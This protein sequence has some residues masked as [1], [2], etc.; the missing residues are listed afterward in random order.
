MYFVAYRVA[1][2]KYISGTSLVTKVD[3]DWSSY[4][5]TLTLDADTDEYFGDFPLVSN[6]SYLVTLYEQI[7]AEPVEADDEVIAEGVFSWSGITS[8]PDSSSDFMI[9]L[10]HDTDTFINEFAEPITYNE[11]SGD[12][13]TIRAVVNRSLPTKVGEDGRTLATF[14]EICIYNDAN[15]GIV[16]VQHGRDTI[17]FSPVYGGTAKT[18]LVTAVVNSDAGMHTLRVR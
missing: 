8:I 18:L 13:K 11:F 9:Q 2:S 4:A 3:A 14:T 16:N 10:S 6:G 17:T 1:D 5:I 15:L 7:G 12:S